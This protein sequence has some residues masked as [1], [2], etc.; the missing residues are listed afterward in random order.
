MQ[1]FYH[2]PD[3]YAKISFRDFDVLEAKRKPFSDSQNESFQNQKQNVA[4][5]IRRILNL[6][7]GDNNLKGSE[8]DKNNGGRTYSIAVHFLSRM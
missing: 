1:K 5:F 4:S 2:S 8:R 3:L 7:S 6:S